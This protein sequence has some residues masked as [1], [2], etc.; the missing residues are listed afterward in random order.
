MCFSAWLWR[1]VQPQRQHQQT[2]EA[3]VW[4][5]LPQDELLQLLYLGQGGRRRGRGRFW[6]AAGR[7]ADIL[8]HLNWIF[9]CNRLYGCISRS[10]ILTDSLRYS[11]LIN[12]VYRISYIVQDRG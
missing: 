2:Q 6:Q 5:V 11:K 12:R 7:G 10:R 3:C 9:R 4:Q 8:Y 1:E